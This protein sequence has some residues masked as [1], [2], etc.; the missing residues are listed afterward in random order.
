MNINLKLLESDSEISNMILYTIKE[1]LN[2][3]FGKALNNLRNTIPTHVK[4][5]I[6]AEPEYGSLVNGKLRYEFGIPDAA[7]SA[8][9]VVDAWANNI[10]I[11]T[12]P[13]VISG[14]G[15]KGGFSINMIK[16]DYSDVL[17]LA[18]SV[19]KDSKSGALLPW[20]EWL[21]LYGGQIIIKNYKVQM[22]PNAN[23]RTGM[24]IMVSSKENWR[25]PPEFAG[26]KN[27]NWISRA[28]TRLDIII[29]DLIQK[30]IEN[31]I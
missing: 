27:N 8:N 1:I 13:I 10:N 5:A 7:N 28:L 29:P 22:G 9:S 21:L 24:A 3:A 17:N 20:L 23:S 15:L 11:E 25:V 2:N 14:N 6:M 4:N 31:N 26:T 19:V 30:E 16:D 18:G 12:I